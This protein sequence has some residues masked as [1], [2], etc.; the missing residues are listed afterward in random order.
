MWNKKLHCP[1]SYLNLSYVSYEN[2]REE[3]VENT[4]LQTKKAHSHELFL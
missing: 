3:E 4:R 1:K 2:I